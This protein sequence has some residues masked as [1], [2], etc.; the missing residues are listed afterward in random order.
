[1]A[2]DAKNDTAPVPMTDDELRAAFVAYRYRRYDEPL[3]WNKWNRLRAHFPALM[4]PQYDNK[5]K[6]YY[7]EPYC[8]GSIMHLHK[9]IQADDIEGVHEFIRL[10]PGLLMRE[11]RECSYRSCAGAAAGKARDLGGA[12][13]PLRRGHSRDAEATGLRRHA[14]VPVLRD[15]SYRSVRH[16]PPWY[17]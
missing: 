12:S 17:T 7:P 9:I 8:W 6:S 3:D 4:A 5:Q 13:G 15:A 11:Q 16:E 14:R 10:D 1:M 2:A